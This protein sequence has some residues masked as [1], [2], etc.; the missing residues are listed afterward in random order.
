MSGNLKPSGHCSKVHRKT[1]QLLALLQ[2]I[3]GQSTRQTL[4]RVINTYLRPITEYAI[5][6]WSPWMQRDIA[7]LERSHRRATK[8]VRGFYNLPY[9]ERMSR[10]H[11]LTPSR[12]RMSCD[13]I[14]TYR[15]LH[16]ANH[17]L[18]QLLQ[19][20]SARS[21]RSNPASLEIQH[22]HINCRRYFYSVR[23]AFLWN[24]LPDT[25]IQSPCMKTFKE[26]LDTYLFTTDQIA[27]IY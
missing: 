20:L 3:F 14:L 22:T 1:S 18:Q 19:Y 16:T 7:L 23:A 21:T 11:L 10:L 24:T 5:Q 12:A 25:I 6:A 26:R 2:R 27:P 13:L 17:P 4:P 8:L 9:E 15:I